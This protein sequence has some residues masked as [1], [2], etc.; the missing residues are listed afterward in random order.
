MPNWKAIGAGALGGLIFGPK[1][2]NVISNPYKGIQKTIE[3]QYALADTLGQRD[4]QNQLM[5]ANRAIGARLASTGAVDP[6]GYAQQVAQDESFS[7]LARL[8]NQLGEG[9][10]RALGELA[11]R[12]TLFNRQAWDDLSQ[13]MINVGSTA[14][15][16][17]AGGGLG[18]LGGGSGATPGPGV[19]RPYTAQEIMQFAP[20]SL[21][22]SLFPSAPDLTVWGERPQRMLRESPMPLPS[23]EM[24]PSIFQSFLREPQGQLPYMGSSMSPV[25]SNDPYLWQRIRQQRMMYSPDMEW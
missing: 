9:K 5:R 24:S 23:T 19:Q 16:A 8:R 14:L 20:P 4:L 3:K 10:A 2:Y 6:Q 13:S 21:N 7:A 1:I 18:G 11:E 22:Q 12:S 25:F 15:L 17:G